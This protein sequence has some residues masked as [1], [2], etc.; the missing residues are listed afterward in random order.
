MTEIGGSHFQLPLERKTN[1][2][3]VEDDAS[4][5]QAASMI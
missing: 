5:G 1:K 2:E 4:G 3:E